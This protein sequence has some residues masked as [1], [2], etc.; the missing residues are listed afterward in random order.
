V[1]YVAPQTA[2]EIKLAQIWRELLGVE[3][4][5]VHDN[6]FALGGH[7]LLAVRMTFRLCKELAVELPLKL[8][9]EFPT[10]AQLSR[11]VDEA[12]KNANDR[13]VLRPVRS[14]SPTASRSQKFPASF[15]QEQLWFIDQLES[16][17][18]VYNL[19]LA[20]RLQGRL[21]RQ[22]LQQ[23]LN[24]LMRRHESLR[25]VFV[26]ENGA[27]VQMILPKTIIDL[28]VTDWGSP[29][30]DRET[31][32]SR[33]VRETVNRPFDLSRSPLVRAELFDLASETHLLLLVIHHIVWDGWSVDVLLRELA[34][35]YAAYATGREPEL[36]ELPVQ[37][38]DYAAWQRAW[39][40]PERIEAHLA[41][42][43][44][45][46]AGVPTVLEL[47]TDRPIA[48][49]QGRQAG[50]YN[51]KLP[52][53]TAAALRQL[54]RKEDA[55][56]LV[57]LLTAFHVLLHRYSR[58]EQIL[59]G[60]PFAGRMV[61]EVENLIGFFVNALPVKGDCAGNPRFTEL[62]RQVRDTVWAVQAHQELPFE[63]LVRALQPARESG[64]NPLFQVCLIYEVTPAE[65]CRLSGLEV[66][67]VK[68]E[69]A[70][71]MFDLTLSVTDGGDELDCA[72]RYNADLF[73]PATIARL[74]GSYQALLA[75]ILANP[76]QRVREIPLLPAAER[77]CLLVDWNR[78][79]V[80]YP[81]DKCVHELFEAQVRKTP[82]AVAVIDGDTQVSYRELNE[83]ANQ[84]AHHLRSL[85]VKAEALVGICVERSLE[86]VVG[87][88]GILKAG[89]AYVPL[90]ADYPVPRLQF[91]LADAGIKLLLTNQPPPADL[92]LR[93][94]TLVNLAAETS[95]LP[96]SDWQDLESMTTAD[97]PAYVIYT[98]GSTGQPK[99]VVVPHRGVVRLVRGQ[100]YAEFNDR[101]RFLL[102]AST[103][104]D[105]STFEL[106]GALLNGAACVIFPNQPLEFA[107]LERILRQQGVTCLWLTAGLFN[108]IVDTHPSVLAAVRQVLTGGEALSVSHVRKVL[109][110]FPH[111]RLTNGYGPTEST[112]FACCYDLKS[113]MTFPN[114]SVPI[115]RPIA[116]TQC[117]ILDAGLDPV[118]V[119]VA[120]ELHIGGVGLARGYLNR[121]E[122]TAEKFIRDPF[123]DKPEA[124]LY[125]TGDLCRYLPDG[126]IEYL[127]RLDQQVKI[128]GFR[129]ELG[130]IEAVLGRH[131][132]VRE[133]VV[134][135][136]EDAAGNKQLVGYVV[137]Q[138][139]QALTVTA[140]R[141]HLLRQLPDY[142]VPAAFVVL[143]Q[144]PLTPNGKVDRKA[145]PAPEQRLATGV[146]YVAPQTATEI[147]LA[148]IWREL[149][150]V[151]QIGL[152]DNFFALG[153]HSLL[154]VRMVN[155]IRRQIK[156]DLSLRMLFQHP[157]IHELAKLL[158]NGHVGKREPEMVRLN[159]GHSNSE[160]Y[161]LID[162]GSLGL[163]KLA[164]YLNKNQRLFASVVPLTETTLK[165]ST[166]RHL[167]ALP[168]MENWASEH[169]A[170]IRSRH[171]AGPVLLAG[172]CFGG[173]L[174][175]EVARQLQAAG[176]QVEAV[177]LL[178]TWMV[179]TTFWWEKKTWIREHFGKLLQQGPRYLWS[180]SSR[181]IGLEKKEL[182]ARLELAIHNDF[183][184][185]VPWAI[186]ARVY[187][188]AMK[189][190]RPAP[191]PTR[192]VLFV[193]QDDWLANAYRPL[194]DSLGADQYF[195][196]GVDVIN[197]P[198]NHVTILDEEHLPELARHFN[199]Y[200]E[201]F[202]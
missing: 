198:G 127:G 8:V 201:Q 166:K 138:A 176:I 88:L 133:S 75:G 179:R 97:Q 184:L 191:L 65:P 69:P 33:R 129:I 19:P 175:F 196:G 3:Q 77:H 157:T 182:A 92:D 99:G 125:K 170:L 123:S 50:E 165:A 124:R 24:H 101:Q 100:N 78:T 57:T 55:T 149:L 121:P 20:L 28:P 180:K 52:A 59:I 131:S 61:G 47:P 25:T 63:Q 188:K 60:T 40:T 177:L 103:A 71:A 54:G 17:R 111:L 119:G 43:R 148:Q 14:D 118:P 70:E 37:Y 34:A 128:R 186:I 105:A 114:G 42:W 45:Q 115:G 89:G 136:R 35:G 90:A 144:L 143:E 85:G 93:G 145:L 16:G 126:N 11:T 193:S 21:N 183:N 202:R 197:V 159:E 167:S 171:P 113:E 162:E 200:L 62:L 86:L 102:L 44:T 67:T 164:H 41:Y 51:F 31:E 13:P 110:R 66:E 122:L 181:R 74:A 134:V 195:T 190:Y 83:R 107:E 109:E 158:Q 152:R 173:V 169:V 140:L 22:A 39:L 27:P 64:R 163:L 172:H 36:P 48:T 9:L 120:G 10:L 58:Q 49:A 80:E 82:E 96:K 38:A 160:L 168:S 174:A 76:R 94:I 199:K 146:E 156:F 153:G 194:N 161:L 187:R 32:V 68:L 106:W 72:L 6:F 112:T 130:E 18:S 150:G 135:A 84:L 26:S 185:Q 132:G 23:S 5:G 79:A 154:A 147:K 56:V 116:N 178:D 73:D 98:S 104:F 81:R 2:T 12:Q 192:G 139:G 53:A 142:M 155:E 1:E 91:M 95:A 29:A 7:S 87:I 4:I 189:S 141:E 151:E 46:L 15:G 108:Q 137:P 30:A 117:Y